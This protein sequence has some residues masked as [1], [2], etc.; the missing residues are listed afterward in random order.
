VEAHVNVEKP[1]VFP[2]ALFFLLNKQT[3]KK[4]TSKAGGG[5]ATVPKSSVM[6]LLRYF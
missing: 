1:E 2:Q 5:G 6:P 3:P 4:L